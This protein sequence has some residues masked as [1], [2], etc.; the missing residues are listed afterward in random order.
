MIEKHAEIATT[1][2][3]LYLISYRLTMLLSINGVNWE[4][5]NPIDWSHIN[6]FSN[7]VLIRVN[8]GHTVEIRYNIIKSNQEER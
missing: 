6:I 3:P 5:N 7:E 4:F 2:I 8:W 1:L